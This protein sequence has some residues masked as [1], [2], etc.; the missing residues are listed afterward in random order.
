[1]GTA[2]AGGKFMGYG[3]EYS[4]PGD[5]GFANRGITV[6]REVVFKVVLGGLDDPPETVRGVVTDMRHGG[7]ELIVESPEGSFRVL[8]EDAALV[9]TRDEFARGAHEEAPRRSGKLLSML[10]IGDALRISGVNWRIT[11]IEEARRGFDKYT[12]IT[13][14]HIRDGGHVV[15]ILYDDQANSWP[16][17]KLTEDS[18]TEINER[19]QRPQHAPQHTMPHAAPPRAT[20]RA[21]PK[22]A[23]PSTPQ[24]HPRWAEY[25]R[26]IAYKAPEN[27]PSFEQWLSWLH[28]SP[29]PPRR[30]PPAPKPRRA[31]PAP[32]PPKPPRAGKARSAYTILGISK[33]ASPAEVRAAF[34]KTAAQYHPD[35]NHS[36]EALARFIEINA[37]YQSLAHEG[38]GGARES[39]AHDFER[40]IYAV[41][42]ARAEGASHFDY[43]PAGAV[44]FYYPV[45]GSYER[46]DTFYAGGKFHIEEQAK[47][48]RALPEGAI[49]IERHGHKVDSPEWQ[50][51]AVG[52][53]AWT[54]RG[55]PPPSAVLP[56]EPEPAL[57]VRVPQNVKGTVGQRRR[58]VGESSA[59][60]ETASVL[61]ESPPPQTAMP[62]PTQ[63]MPKWQRNAR[64]IFAGLYIITVSKGPRG[65]KAP[66]WRLMR[67]EADLGLYHLLSQAKGAATQ[68]FT[69][70]FHIDAKPSMAMPMAPSMPEFE[71]VDEQALLPEAP[72][73]GIELAQP[74][75]DTGACIPWVKVTRNPENYAACVETARRLGPM[76]TARKV[77]DLLSDQ[78]SKEDQEVF[79]VVLCNVRGELRGVAEVARGQR[80]KVTVGID[81][82][83]RVVISTGAEQFVCVHQ[84]P[85]GTATPSDSDLQLTKQIKEAAE[86]FGNDVVFL[87]HVVVGIKEYY[88]IE[89]K[90]LYKV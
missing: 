35:V 68:D 89:E 80:S 58:I 48:V 70:G 2:K 15:G 82:V 3:P 46:R 16:I 60:Q 85:S 41:E 62:A 14:Q 72:S 90:K 47:S 64:G 88:S 20:R 63:S 74:L 78:L 6:G 76:D 21:A 50:Q 65:G 11:N 37:A 27:T 9:A 83:M 49:S 45:G 87:D 69:K 43:T 36:P 51:T 42:R 61:H 29:T 13:E 1:M 67:G 77:Y 12:L 34:R 38:R 4:R 40:I 44:R 53:R 25:Q 55:Y 56:D 84:H 75:A 31:A 66:W 24:S 32:K 5:G 18:F 79:L 39:V 7:R 8:T 81:D 73:S 17:D 54:D 59:A 23:A 52:R 33:G 28:D 22:P 30:A 10:V 57:P 86:L 19:A 26:A 71:D